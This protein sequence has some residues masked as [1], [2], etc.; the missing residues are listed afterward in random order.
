MKTRTPQK[1]PG[2][3]M[4]QSTFTDRPMYKGDYYNEY[5]DANPVSE[6]NV[7]PFEKIRSTSRSVKSSQSLSRPNLSGISDNIKK[8]M[9]KIMNRISNIS[10]LKASYAK[11]SQGGSNRK[12]P[13]T[14]QRRTDASKPFSYRKEQVLG[15]QRETQVHQNFDFQASLDN[16]RNISDGIRSLIEQMQA[17]SR[18]DGFANVPMGR[19]NMRSLNL[20]MM[21][22]VRSV[23]FS[24][25][26]SHQVNYD[27][28]PT[29]AFDEDIIRANGFWP[30]K[31]EAPNRTSQAFSQ[32]NMSPMSRREAPYTAL[33][34]MANGQGFSERNMPLPQDSFGGTMNSN[35][36]QLPK[37]FLNETDDVVLTNF[38]KQF[39]NTQPV[40][41]SIQTQN[42]QENY[43]DTGV[44][45]EKDFTTDLQINGLNYNDLIKFKQKIEK[46]LNY[47]Q[48]TASNMSG[49]VGQ[50]M[51][52]NQPKRL[53]SGL[54]DEELKHSSES[55]AKLAK[56]I[57]PKE[58][59][60][61]KSPLGNNNS[62]QQPMEC[63]Y[64]E[65]D[66]SLLDI[67]KKLK[68]WDGI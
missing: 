31:K 25:A 27:S 29:E 2:L 4:K 36:F 45:D 11:R 51:N 19:K 49:P 54:T 50:F 40:A 66:A 10:G 26:N 42:F 23:D 28:H 63:S 64:E 47:K 24:Q 52:L 32:R 8:K 59:F 7:N 37:R 1:P 34:H 9:D 3:N 62:F 57:E 65:T 17:T 55:L 39:L 5:F 15:S 60:T 16:I 58:K 35:R 18:T 48:E 22:T 67:Q 20:N 12:S 43:Y 61:M 14:W 46:Q 38:K 33:E 44:G 56:L 6:R 53:S 21:N 13:D 68:N 30:P 41:Q